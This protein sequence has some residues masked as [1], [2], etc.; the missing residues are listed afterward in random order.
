LGDD[1][2][3][4]YAPL[5]LA[6]LIVNNSMV[7]VLRNSLEN[8]SPVDGPADPAIDL[9]RS[10]GILDPGPEELPIRTV[11]GPP[12]PTQVTLLLTTACNFRC[13]YCYAADPAIV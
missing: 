1:R 10:L 13:S 2:F 12:E 3:L 11:S 9:F 8:P 5:Q 4:V 7:N 6:A